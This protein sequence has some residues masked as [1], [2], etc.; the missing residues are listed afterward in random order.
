MAEEESDICGRFLIYQ[1]PRGVMG[2]AVRAY[3]PTLVT[4]ENLQRWG[5]WVDP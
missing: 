1:V 2:W 5:L 3:T 4:T